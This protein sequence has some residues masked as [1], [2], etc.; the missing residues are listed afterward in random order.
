MGVEIRACRD[1][2]LAAVTALASRVFCNDDGD[3]G[4]DYPLL[5]APENQ[6]GLQLAV[7]R[8]VPVAHVGVCIRDAVILGAPLRVAG[9]GAVCTDPEYRGR[10]LAST[11]ME[12]ARRYARD[13]GASLMLISGGRGLYHRLGYVTVG[14]FDRYQWTAA[15]LQ[16]LRRP[17]I[18]LSPYAEADLPEVAALHQ[19][20]PIRFL[21]PAAD[22]RKLLNAGLLMNR[23]SQLWLVRQE[24]HLAA[25]IG[26]LTPPPASSASR[27]AVRI[28]EFG[29]SKT[30]LAA[31]L[32]VL[33]DRWG[34]TEAILVTQAG[35]IEFSSVAGRHGWRPQT[36]PFPGTLGVIDASTLISSVGPVLAERAPAEYEI[37]AAG[38]A[39]TLSADGE[40]YRIE[41]AGSLAALL[42]GGDTDEAR[43]IPPAD[44]RVRQLLER[45]FPIPL[46]WQGYNYV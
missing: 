31:A 34:L 23:P 12:E 20:E 7:D 22:W 15:Q 42:F 32:P 28:H 33:L 27:P 43:A 24:G 30:A 36:I 16:P 6:D 14:R 5:F 44:G 46:L 3:M 10:G 40:R 18:E 8:G 39:M 2:E 17:E 19:R 41:G 9:I 37:E 21:R 45:L 4:A 35:D 11:L 38:D 1:G 25:Y 29:G 26:V 13:R